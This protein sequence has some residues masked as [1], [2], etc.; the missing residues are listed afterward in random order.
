MGILRVCATFNPMFGCH[1][2]RR[3]AACRYIRTSAYQARKGVNPNNQ[4]G[5]EYGPLWPVPVSSEDSLDSADSDTA[6]D[7]APTSPI[8]GTLCAGNY[9]LVLDERLERIQQVASDRCHSILP[10]VEGLIDRGNVGALCRTADALGF[11]AVQCIDTSPEKVK[12]AR[13]NRTSKGAEKW[14]DVQRTWGT[15]RCVMHLRACGYRILVS[16][17]TAESVSIQDI[18]WTR[19]TA[20]IL[21][22]EVN[23]AS[24]EAIE[25]ADQAV[26]VPMAHSFTE[27]FNVSVAAALILSEA[28]RQRLCCLLSENVWSEAIT[29]ID[30]TSVVCL[31]I[32]V[33]TGVSRL[34]KANA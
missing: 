1:P 3:F 15:R 30:A 23:G 6:D 25:L 14:L 10:V 9:Q 27:S 5:D 26:T 12:S 19:P 13:G 2:V 16:Q 21:G 8:K 11:G 34:E 29:D 7:D 18:D 22:N 28:R 24:A 4:R 32:F 20:F 17:P 33:Y 31:G